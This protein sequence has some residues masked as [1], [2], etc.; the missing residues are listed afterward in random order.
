MHARR[1]ARL[2]LLLLLLPLA[3]C[4]RGAEGPAD[5]GARFHFIVYGDCRTG[6]DVHRRIVQSMLSAEPRLVI[7]TGDLVTSDTPQ[8]WDDFREIVRPLRA[9]AAYLPAAGNHDIF[10]DQGGLAKEFQLERLYYDRRMGDLHVFILDSNQPDDPDQLRWLD[11]AFT[12][13]TARHRIVVFHYPPI[14]YDSGG[15]GGYLGAFRKALARLKPCAVFSGH[16]H[17]FYTLVRDDVRYVVTGGGGAP[18]YGEGPAGSL[19]RSFHHYVVCTLD[20]R[21]IAARVLDE[22]GREDRAL[23]FRVCRHP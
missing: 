17:T 7:N 9:R 15:D 13:S 10:S 18:L 5:A 2:C 3:A 11:G 16:D 12:R 23:T 19:T 22:H 21:G 4:D 1:G 20:S 6:H 14:G 8:E